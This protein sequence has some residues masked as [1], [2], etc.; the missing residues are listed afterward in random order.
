MTQHDVKFPPRLQHCIVGKTRMQL[1]L[2]LDDV[3][4]HVGLFSSDPVTLRD[5]LHNVIS[6]RLSVDELRTLA[7]EA[8]Y[9]PDDIAGDGRGKG[10]YARELVSYAERREQLEAVRDA[11]VALRPDLK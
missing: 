5:A 10:G 8:K 3:L 2:L 6:K 9:D 7:L 11:L 4:P 1:K